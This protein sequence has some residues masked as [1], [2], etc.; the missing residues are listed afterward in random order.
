[1]SHFGLVCPAVP[2]HLNPM[3]ALGRE[4]RDR[5]HRVT[6][7]AL[8]DA[9]P[10]ARAAGLDFAPI[11]LSEFP[12]GQLREVTTTLGTL[13]GLGALRYTLQLF[14]RETAVQLRELP[15]VY[16]ELQFDAVLCDQVSPG[17]GTAADLVGL[18]YVTICNALPIDQDPDV[19]PC[20]MPWSYRPS[21]WGRLRNRAGY[22]VL[23]RLSRPIRHDINAVRERHGLPRYRKLAD[24]ASRRAAIWQLPRE[25]DFP[26][27]RIPS[28]RHCVGPFRASQSRASVAFPYDRLDGRP[29]VYASMGTLQNG[30]QWLF[31][32]IAAACADLPVQLVL[33]LGRSDAA[34]LGPLPGN[35]LVVRYAPQL[36]ILARASLTITHAG[37]NTTLE[38]LAAGVPLV[39]IPITND[40]PAVAARIAWSGTGEMIPL[41]RLTAERLK[42][43]VGRVLSEPRYRARAQQ[44]QEAIVRAGGVM[45]AADIVE[46]VLVNQAAVA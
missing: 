28:T 9:E 30:Q 11:A 20:V 19:P 29:L 4:L 45:R 22:A 18:P 42:E 24:F 16:R 43:A 36:E 7:V 6:L 23:D 21:W 46:S 5:G 35:P 40:Q 1:M 2:G 26:R 38:S 34:D 27:R 15:A 14:R 17:A 3:C 13:T 32:T 12:P 37:M 44:L 33:S 25:L 31:H 8:A 10:A 39:A 41:R